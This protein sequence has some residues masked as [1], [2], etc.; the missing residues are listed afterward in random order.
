ML[1]IS[2]VVTVFLCILFLK[3]LHISSRLSSIILQN[4]SNRPILILLPSRVT[5][6]IGVCGEIFQI[7][8]LVRRVREKIIRS[9]LYSAVC[10]NCAYCTAYTYEET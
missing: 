7:H 9:V 2:D 8:D 3:S 1:K 4:I 5:I 6:V 10:N